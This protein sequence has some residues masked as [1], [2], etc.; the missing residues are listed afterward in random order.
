MASV[1]FPRHAPRRFLSTRKAL[2]LG[3]G[4]LLSLLICSGLNTVRAISRLQASN[5]S[6]L[7]EFLAR[8]NHLNQLRSAIYLSGTYV[9]DYLLEPDA[10]MA[11]QSRLALAD[12]RGEIQAIVRPDSALGDP[13][14]AV[15]RDL[16]REIDDYWRTLDPVLGWNPGQRHAKGYAFLRD[17]VLPRRS[18]ML[19][20]ADTI[21]SVNQQQLFERDHR[22]VR[23]F[24]GFRNES[25]ATVV[26]MFLCGLGLACAAGLH[27]LRLQRETMDHLKA[28]TDARQ[29]LRNLSAR[30]M[31]V[32]ENER[33]RI[34][35]ELHDA[36]G[37]AL[38]GVQFEL[39]DLAVALSDSTEPLR[40]RVDRIRGLVENSVAMVR[41]MALLLRPSML[42]DLGLTAALKWQS[43]EISRSTGVRI[44]VQDDLPG[45]LPEE[46]KVCI[47]R[48]VQEALTN[49]CRHARASSVVIT[50][51]GGEAEVTVA[52]RDDGRG[53]RVPRAGGLGLI[54]IEERVESLGGALTVRSEPGK[55]TTIEARLPLPR[56][57]PSAIGGQD[58]IRS[59]AIFT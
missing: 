27:I 15:Y 39:H 8:E 5:E 13:G 12:T 23:M 54:G 34:S 28:V 22:L 40:G 59:D 25:L 47:F 51:A 3:F 1:P 53:F 37:Q 49:V 9:R 55:G 50:L 26:A 6:I 38:S 42:D 58:Q 36:V 31:E 24:S 41:N 18:S 20:I 44:E 11:E 45:E 35:R 7:A 10:E 48:V 21:A 16:R 33:K 2:A 43:K 46:H 57:V 32:Q 56:P 52:I 30:L 4:I 29:E 19:R 17:E 14:G